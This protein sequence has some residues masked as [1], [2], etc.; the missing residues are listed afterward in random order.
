MA[1]NTNSTI[2]AL[3]RKIKKYREQ[4]ARRKEAEKKIAE[5]L[6]K[7]DER[8]GI[9]RTAS[10]YKA[11]AKKIRETREIKRK[12][13]ALVKKGHTPES[14]LATVAKNVKK[15]YRDY[16]HNMRQVKAQQYKKDYPENTWS[17]SQ[18]AQLRRSIGKVSK[19]K[20]IER[21]HGRY[22]V[23]LDFSDVTYDNLDKKRVF[24]LIKKGHTYTDAI[25]IAH[26]DTKPNMKFGY[27]TPGIVHRDW[28]QGEIYQLIKEGDKVQAS[29]EK[30][31]KTG[32]IKQPTK[33]DIGKGNEEN[34]FRMLKAQGDGQKVYRPATFKEREAFSSMALLTSLDKML[35]HY[36]GNDPE[37]KDFIM[38]K[39]HEKGRHLREFISQQSIVSNMDITNLFGYNMGDGILDSD[40]VGDSMINLMRALGIDVNAPLGNGKGVGERAYLLGGIN[41]DTPLLLRAKL[42][43]KGLLTYTNRKPYK[44]KDNKSYKKT[45]AKYEDVRRSRTI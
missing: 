19:M 44:V 7:A 34:L 15:A 26:L 42:N 39:A 40:R 9:K 32:K 24:D 17:A 1:R 14:A 28:K 38:Q 36:F 18:D 4:K 30:A 13:N 37:L 5:K 10:E 2:K 35:D 8:K 33:D 45:L 23:K 29:N 27:K 16:L 21:S 25:A 22:S 41:D 11:E 31:Y 43:A 20:P 12:I 6:R 3:D